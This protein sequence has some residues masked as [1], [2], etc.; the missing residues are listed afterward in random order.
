[1]DIY[2]YYLCADLCINSILKE[3][4]KYY[5][6][7]ISQ[8]KKIKEGDKQ[9]KSSER[10]KVVNL[11]GEIER[12]EEDEHTIGRYNAN[13][14]VLIFGGSFTNTISILLLVR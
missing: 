2:V 12:W 10:K 6:K 14:L 8:I 9:H 11:N 5:N 4:I 1:M 7:S 3:R 13:V